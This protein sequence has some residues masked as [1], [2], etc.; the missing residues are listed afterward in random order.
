MLFQFGT[1]AVDKSRDIPEH[2]GTSR[3][4]PGLR[5]TSR[6]IPEIII[7]IKKIRKIE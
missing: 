1:G 2:L 6:N 5:D 7:I 3:N 4:I